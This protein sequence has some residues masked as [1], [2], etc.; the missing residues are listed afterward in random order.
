MVIRRWTQSLEDAEHAKCHADA[1][2]SP[3]AEILLEL[4]PEF[5]LKE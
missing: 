3:N 5:G 1:D 2:V 4:Q